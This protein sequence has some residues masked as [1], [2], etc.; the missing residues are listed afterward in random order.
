M[1][2][3]H[4]LISTTVPSPTIVNNITGEVMVAGVVATQPAVQAPQAPL[5]PVAAPQA[6]VTAAGTPVL[7]A[8]EFRRALPDRV[9]KSVNQELID[10]VNLVLADPELYELSC[11]NSTGRTC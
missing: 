8:D 5:L 11:M 2:F 10:R 6:P 9:K 3:S 1:P 4:G 7:T